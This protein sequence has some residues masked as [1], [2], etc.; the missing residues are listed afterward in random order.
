MQALRASAAPSRSWVMKILVRRFE[1]R[2]PRALARA[3]AAIG[4]LVIFLGVLL[5][6][7]GYWWGALLMLVGALVLVVAGL[8]FA[9][10]SSAA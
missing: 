2:R 9:L 6:V 7:T 4:I 8:M 1:Y 10:V 5:C 3:R